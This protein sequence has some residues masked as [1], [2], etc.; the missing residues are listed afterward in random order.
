M[1]VGLVVVVIGQVAV[2]PATV[3]RRSIP[4]TSARQVIGPTIPSEAMPRADKPRTK[5]SVQSED[6][7]DLHWRSLSI[8]LVMEIS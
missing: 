4:L 8:R 3:S 2:A 1:V 7:V 5:A 6:P